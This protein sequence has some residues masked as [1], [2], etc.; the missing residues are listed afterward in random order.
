MYNNKYIYLLF[1]V[2]TSRNGLAQKRVGDSCIETYSNTVGKCE[3]AKD[4]R[5]A[6]ED[7]HS[8]GIRPTFCR[9]DFDNPL[10]CCRDGANIL[11]TPTFNIKQPARPSN[12]VGGKRLSERK[13]DEYSK[14]VTQTVDFLPLL[15]DPDTMSI[16]APKCNY[17]KVE[18]IVGGETTETGEFPHMAAIGFLSSS[19][20][21]EFQCGGS[22][23][24]DKFVLTAGH[25]LHNPDRT[26]SSP[27]PSVVRLGDQNINPR[28]QD[29]ANPIE[30]Q[31][32]S[33]K[34]HPAY[35]PPNRYNDI[36]LIELISKVEFEP[37]IRPAC[38]W[39]RNGFG[40]HTSAVATGWGVVNTRTRET[41]DE[42][43]KVSLTLYENSYC[44]RLLEDSQNR[45]WEGFRSTQLCA[46][47]IRGGKDSCQG[48]SG[49]PLQLA[50]KENHCV[51]HILG[52]TSFGKGCAS[53]GEPAVYTRVSSYV[54]WIESQ[55]WPQG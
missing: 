19:G 41:S 10:V 42:L 17:A 8:N 5:S 53:S 23:I 34:K 47:E 2:F 50:S 21:Y 48:D 12:N 7:F 1:L 40:G 28:V 27:I 25:C 33:V 15:P 43:Q 45:H 39:H 52:I 13:C 46:G 18:L 11:Q 9:V 16:S 14:G 31:V 38:L 29:G 26:L 37:N 6:K 49:G 32:K 20:N 35:K 36:G 4:C 55:V 30:I 3:V 24:S 54:D 51:F 44:D 22:L